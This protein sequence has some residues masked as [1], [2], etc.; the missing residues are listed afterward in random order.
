MDLESER[1]SAKLRL[2]ITTLEGNMFRVRIREKNP[3]R[4]RYEVEGALA[5][6]PKKV[7]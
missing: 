7:E 6:E 4:P 5:G 3:L 1:A 2:E